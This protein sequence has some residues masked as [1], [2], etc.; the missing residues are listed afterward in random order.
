MGNKLMRFIRPDKEDKVSSNEP[1][2][3]G[4]YSAISGLFLRAVWQINSVFGENSE[5]KTRTIHTLSSSSSHAMRHSK[6][7]LSCVNY[8]ISACIVSIGLLFC[9]AVHKSLQPSVFG[10]TSCIL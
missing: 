8:F 3:T 1:I 4:N 10:R 7:F 2:N 9:S 6:V 5:Q